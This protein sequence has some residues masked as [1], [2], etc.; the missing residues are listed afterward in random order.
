MQVLYDTL[1]KYPNRKDD[2]KII[3]NTQNSGSNITRKNGL[4]SLS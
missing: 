2:I 3:N 4:G 1:A